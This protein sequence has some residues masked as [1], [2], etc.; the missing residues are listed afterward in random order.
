VE[1]QL[2][3]EPENRRVAIALRTQIHF[4]GLSISRQVK[5]ASVERIPDIWGSAAKTCF[6]SQTAQKVLHD[7]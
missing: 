7:V 6:A 5:D 4:Y 2:V 1:R 3:V